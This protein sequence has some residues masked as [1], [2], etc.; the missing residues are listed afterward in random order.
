MSEPYFQRARYMVQYS[1]MA[2]KSSPQR[3]VRI[4]SLL[5]LCLSV[6]HFSFFFSFIHSLMVYSLNIQC[7]QRLNYGWCW[8][9]SQKK[10]KASKKCRKKENRKLIWLHPSLT[11]MSINKIFRPHFGAVHLFV[12]FCLWIHWQFWVHLFVLKICKILF[13][14]FGFFS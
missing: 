6:T 9:S 5:P 8:T 4:V 7:S 2:E 14:W 11:W 12:C 10:W 1:G 3:K 13:V